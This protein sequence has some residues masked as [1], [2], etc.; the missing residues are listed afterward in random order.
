M[1]C[2]EKS[3]LSDVKLFMCALCARSM[4][5]QE[6]SF[7]DNNCQVYQTDVSRSDISKLSKTQDCSESNTI[8]MPHYVLDVI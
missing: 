2:E 3:S 8:V 6:M 1:A 5:L 7:R 4:K